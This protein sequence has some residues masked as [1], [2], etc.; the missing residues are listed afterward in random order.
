VPTA[1][2]TTFYPVHDGFH[3]TFASK[4]SV[5]EP[6]TL[7]LDIRTT[8]GRSVRLLKL[9]HAQAGS[10]TMSWG[11]LNTAG[12][13]VAAGTYRF[14][15]L[16]DDVAGNR[17]I[18]AS[19]NVIVSLRH[20]VTKTSSITRNGS[21]YDFV[22]GSAS[23]AGGSPTQSAFKPNGV[24]LFNACSTATDEIG[25][26]QYSF[27]LP[28]AISYTS[29]GIASYGFS[30]D[31]PVGV[32]SLIWNFP[33]S[34]ADVVAGVAVTNRSPAWTNLGGITASGH[35]SA[36][37]VVTIAIGLVNVT[38]PAL[39]DIGLVRLTVTYRVLS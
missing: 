2:N 13:L 11:G 16:A 26:A 24:R 7:W 17:R 22:D 21:G 15:F 12:H 19:Y 29:L 4:V 30:V 33:H 5:N 38:S 20:L 6:G 14:R 23:C 8:D 28:G 32:G 3:D 25:L 37:R 31:A 39:Y 9:P 1:A 35:V 10:F 18:G 27:R 34:D 36:G